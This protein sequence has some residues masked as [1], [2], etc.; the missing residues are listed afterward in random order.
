MKIMDLLSKE[1]IVLDLKAREKEPAIIEL[2]DTLVKLHKLKSSA[3]AIET[4]MQREKLGS[5]GIGQGVAIPHCRCDIV[6]EQM[7]VLA[8]S[9]QGVEFN[10]LDGNPVNIIF[11]LIGPAD[12]KGEHLQAMA[13]IS[14]I[15]K[16]KYLRQSL[17]EAKTPEDVIAII[18]QADA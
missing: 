10:S 16:D 12:S 1:T 15:L 6:K 2:V 7:A 8:F 9:K 13:K 4:I 18:Q 11:L 14:K 17:M 3:E 5:T